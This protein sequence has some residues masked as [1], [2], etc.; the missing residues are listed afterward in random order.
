MIAGSRPDHLSGRVGS[1]Q[2]G[3]GSGWVKP[4]FSCIIFR[5]GWVGLGWVFFGFESTI[6]A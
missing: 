3:F 6:L 4:D 1:G 2:V 5:S